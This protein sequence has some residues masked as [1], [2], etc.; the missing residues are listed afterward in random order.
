MTRYCL[1]CGKE[2]GPDLETCCTDG[3]LVVI[4][5]EGLFKKKENFFTLDGKPLTPEQLEEMRRIASS[6]YKASGLPTPRSGEPESAEDQGL[7]LDTVVSSQR[8][9]FR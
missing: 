1:V 8:E 2:W 7:F 3:S 9:T 5:V 6:R 4:K